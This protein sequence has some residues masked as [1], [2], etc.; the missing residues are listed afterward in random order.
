VAAVPVDRE[1]ARRRHR[2]ESYRERTRNPIVILADNVDKAS[3]TGGILRA[4]DAFLAEKVLVNRPD[5]DVFGAMGAQHWQ[6]VEWNADLMAAIEL[7]C[8]RGYT[9]VALEQRPEA[10]PIWAFPFPRKTLL[11]IGAEMFGVSDAI[12]R[13]AQNIVYIPQAGLVKSLNVTTATAIALYEYSRQ[14]WMR[15]FEQPTKNLEPA[16][17]SLRIERGR[18]TLEASERGKCDAG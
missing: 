11:A 3:N 6:P 8:A 12:I 9:V 10:E 1:A 14:H 18:E 7:Y 15:G 16:A 13:R 17:L 4:A 2:H 5:P